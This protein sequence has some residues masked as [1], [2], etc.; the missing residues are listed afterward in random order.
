MRSGERAAACD[1]G[2]HGAVFS[3]MRSGERAVC[4]ERR[5]A[6]ARSEHRRLK[7]MSADDER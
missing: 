3:L 2:L 6:C 5:A 7:I 4:G 1:G